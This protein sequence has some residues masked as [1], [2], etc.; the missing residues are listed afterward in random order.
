[1]NCQQKSKTN[2]YGLLEHIITTHTSECYPSGQGSITQERQSLES[3]GDAYV[4][5][6][7]KSILQTQH[8]GLQPI[9]FRQLFIKNPPGDI[10]GLLIFSQ[11]LFINSDINL[12]LFL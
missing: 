6:K 1:M 7:L 10:T 12:Q 5:N 4:T 8:C 3:S 11:K 9:R 2:N